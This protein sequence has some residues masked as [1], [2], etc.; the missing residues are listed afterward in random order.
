[1]AKDCPRCHLTN[2]PTA[3][4]CDCG[5]DFETGR[6]ERSYLT[7][8]Q[9]RRAVVVGVGLGAALAMFAGFRLIAQLVRA[10]VGERR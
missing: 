7:P 6:I 4:R 5:Y 8:A 2:P 9:T 3:K 10:R 1:M